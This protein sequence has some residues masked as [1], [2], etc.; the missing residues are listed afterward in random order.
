MSRSF[1]QPLKRYAPYLLL[2]LVVL[3][4][5]LAPGYILT[6]DAVFTPHI[7][8]PA[9][10]SSEYLWQ[11]LLHI[12]NFAVPAQVLE[13]AIFVGIVL[14]SAIG[15]HRLLDWLRRRT[16]IPNMLR[17][18][19]PLYAAGVLY[20]SNPFTYDR[21]MAGQYGVLLG[22]ALL[23][24]AL[25]WVLEFAARP[26]RAEMFK[27]AG[28]TVAISIVSLPTLGE[29]ALLATC[30]MLASAWQKRGQT[31]VLLAYAR[32]GLVALGIVVLTSCYWLVP[33][34][35][36]RGTTATAIAGFTTAHTTAFATNGSNPL[37]RAAVVLRLQG[38]WAE[39]HHL[40]LLP[41]QKLPG[42]GTVRLL[43]W[44]MVA[45]GLVVLWR[46]SRWLAAWLTMTLLA[47][48]LLA[49]GLFS[50]QLTRLGYREPQK[51]AGLVALVFT[52]C[53]A[54]G[55]A[56]A[57]TWMANRR[58]A[59]GEAAVPALAALLVL[60][61]APTMYWGFAGQLTPRAY[62]AGL[63]TANTYLNTQAGSF[64]SV[65]LPWHQYMSFGF[66]G[67]II[68]TPAA[69]FFQRPV[70]VSNNPELGAIQPPAGQEATQID[71][72]VT[73]GGA[74]AAFAVQLAA[75]N[76]RYILLAKDYDFTSYAYLDTTPHI[77]RA[78]DTPSLAIYENA[79]WKGAR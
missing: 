55:V 38:F 15:M 64:Q 67:R 41:Q 52:V 11:W 48:V 50:A 8:A 59:A 20:A 69:K 3:A 49:A 37:A 54:F 17:G 27:V 77:R 24:L 74:H 14:G 25:L 39:S 72:I 4:P 40:F 9:A 34:L 1:V 19:W 21:F 58:H 78:L 32:R 66:A 60:L 73:P 33:L 51:F 2:V 61:F 43:I 10:V 45:V 28:A 57:R 79:L 65:F 12:L 42:W 26:G 23:P 18:D 13:K 29:F 53:F 75:R 47:A 35:S 7:A 31:S 46:R 16:A 30:A 56:Q 6:L 76:V 44:L 22:Y 70:I 68:A 71:R 5:L 63:Y 62:P 36:G